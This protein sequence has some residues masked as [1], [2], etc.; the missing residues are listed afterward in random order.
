MPDWA[1]AE[2]I[3]ELR[4]SQPVA[5][6]PSVATSPAPQAAIP[7]ANLNYY[8]PV[9][10]GSAVAY[11][12]FWLRFVA[13]LIDLLLLWIVQVMFREV[14]RAASMGPFFPPNRAPWSMMTLGLSGGLLGFFVQW[15]YFSLME[16]SPHR[17]TLGKMA[18]G[19]VATDLNGNTL[20]FG[21]AT[22][23]YFAKYLSGLILYIGYMMAGFTDRK[24]ALHD[25]VA[26]T[27]VVKKML[28]QQM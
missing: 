11:A 25:M 24:Q 15:L 10:P 6:A 2:S 8:N 4:P 9:L 28:P 1:P 13:N 16:S 17:A 23:R 20:T 7:A 18:M 5:P 3:A 22:G 21:R 27:L 14:F 12:G 26:G 19:I